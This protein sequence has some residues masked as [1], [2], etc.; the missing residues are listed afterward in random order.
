MVVSQQRA[1]WQQCID[2]VN[3]KIGMATGALFIREHFKQQSKDK[4]LYIYEISMVFGVDIIVIISSFVVEFS[5][6]C[7][8]WAT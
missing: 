7:S 1:R 4:V 2:F 5:V 3:D 6:I 8:S